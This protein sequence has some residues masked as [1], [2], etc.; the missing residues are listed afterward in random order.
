MTIAP[1]MPGKLPDEAVGTMPPETGFLP[2]RA[3]WRRVFVALL[4]I[5]TSA[6]NDAGVAADGMKAYTLGLE[7]FMQFAPTTSRINSTASSAP[8]P[9]AEMLPASAP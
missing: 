9:A 1:A 2:Q 7:T 3:T 8:M 4:A 5:I 6:A